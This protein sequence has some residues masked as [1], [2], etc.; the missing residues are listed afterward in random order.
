MSHSGHGDLSTLDPYFFWD[1]SKLLM[2]NQ[3][4]LKIR[5][6][7]LLDWV[8]NHNI[9]HFEH[10]PI[11]FGFRTIQQ[12]EDDYSKSKWLAMIARWVNFDGALR[13][14]SKDGEK[15]TLLNDIFYYD[16]C[17]FDSH[18]TGEMW[19][20]LLRDCGIDVAK[21]IEAE[22]NLRQTPSRRKYPYDGKRFIFNLDEES[23]SVYWEWW[24]D[25]EGPGYEV[26][27]EFNSLGPQ[28]HHKWRYSGTEYCLEN[29][30]YVYYYWHWEEW[31]KEETEEGSNILKLVKQR[32]EKRQRKKAIKL[33]KQQGTWKKPRMPGTWID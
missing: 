17:G 30:P 7:L 16:S 31:N 24:T 29:W 3:E 12:L 13:A 23:P 26:A 5:R 2:V 1:D 27:E 8:D 19:L 32:F 15:K 28:D 33:A 21:Y 6:S 20:D 4:T 10:S 25:I 22:Y 18:K 14:A 9:T 11:V